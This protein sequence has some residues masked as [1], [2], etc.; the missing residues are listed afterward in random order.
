MADLTAGSL[1]GAPFEVELRRAGLVLA[2]PADRTLLEVVCDVLPD[3]PSG[4]REGYCGAC[5]TA[6]VAGEVDHRDSFLTDEERATHRTMMICVG[7]SCG[8]RLVLDL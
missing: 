1:L 5:Q 7:R 6:V 8:A 3:T 4:C 2:V